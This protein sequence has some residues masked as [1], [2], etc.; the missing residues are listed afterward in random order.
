MR[1]PTDIGR[2][3]L[4]G[5][6]LHRLGYR[7]GLVR[8][9]T[10]TI[11]LGWSLGGGLWLVLAT[12][13]LLE[14]VAPALV[15]LTTIGA[16]VRLLAVIPLLFLCE[17]W[18]A[19]RVGT[20]VDMILRSGIV[21]TP[22]RPALERAMARTARLADSGVAE[23]ICALAAVAL[24]LSAA[25]WSVP[26][27]AEAVELVRSPFD[28]GWAGRWY[29]FVCLP[30]FRFV[31][32]RW[33][34]R[35]ALWVHLLWRVAALELHLMP[36][37]PDGAGGLG[38]LEVVHTHFIPLVLAVSVGWFQVPMRGSYLLLFG[39]TF[40]YL[41]STLGLGLFVS[42]ISSTQQQAMMTSVF[43]FLVPMIYLSGFIFPI[44][45]MPEPIQAVTVIV[46]LRYFLVIVRGIF[47]KGVGF[48][49]LWPQFAALA[50]WGLVVVGLAA[51][52]ARRRG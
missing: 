6:P 40:I 24:S 17:T 36:T 38:Y 44:E 33:L 26:G 20:F 35:L 14:G 19:P 31:M 10:N 42:T 11:R 49:V 3:S 47:L 30:V 37:H 15:S 45:N 21:P 23:A 7:L 8:E 5:G 52:R 28:A 51:A 43:F 27:T 41:L 12:L 32:M 18:L 29:A 4:L 39:M 25:E 1:A 9:A 16:H 34:W 48:E 46:P 50:V 22:S 13:A 2:F